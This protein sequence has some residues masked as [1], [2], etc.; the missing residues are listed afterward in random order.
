MKW[1]RMAVECGMTAPHERGV[2]RRAVAIIAQRFPPPEGCANAPQAGLLRMPSCAGDHRCAP[3]HLEIPQISTLFSSG[4]QR[5]QFVFF[6]DVLRDI[7]DVSHVTVTLGPFPWRPRLGCPGRNA[8]TRRM[9]WQFRRHLH[10]Q[11][12]NSRP[13][14]MRLTLVRDVQEP[15]APENGLDP[16]ARRRSRR[17]PRCLEA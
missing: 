14:V 9:A 8:Q 11:S 7:E 10:I 17:L 13:G 16:G 2:Y 5:K 6:L 4:K 3:P 15:E 12:R 1:S